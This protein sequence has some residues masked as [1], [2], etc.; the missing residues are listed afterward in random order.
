VALIL[1]VLAPAVRLVPRLVESEPHK[2]TE[3]TRRPAGKVK[4]DQ[5]K[6]K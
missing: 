1:R 6:E 3:A 4:K 5:D 2:P